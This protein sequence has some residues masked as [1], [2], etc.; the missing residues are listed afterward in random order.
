VARTTDPMPAATLAMLEKAT[1]AENQGDAAKEAVGSPPS[2]SLGSW[3]VATFSAAEKKT[4]PSVAL[5]AVSPL[6]KNAS[7][8]ATDEADALRECLE[9]L[10]R[11]QLQSLAKR[12]RV[13]AALSNHELV[14]SLL[15][16]MTAV[17]QRPQEDDGLKPSRETLR[18]DRQVV[19]T[20]TDTIITAQE[21]CNIKRGKRVDSHR[22]N[23]LPVPSAVGPEAEPAANPSA[24]SQCNA[25]CDVCKLPFYTASGK[26]VCVDCRADNSLLQQSDSDTKVCTNCGRGDS[27]ELLMLCDSCENAC[28]T[29]CCE[30]RLD[31]I[32]ESD[33]F[34][35]TCTHENKPSIQHTGSMVSPARK[36]G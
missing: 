34:C 14:G 17:R 3:D 33:W 6:M 28:H 7:G 12:L 5:F 11:K 36:Q 35:G 13:S 16:M 8:D 19:P 27:E 2:T 21:P 26:M 30:P 24:D 9:S 22:D 18:S 20:D 1:P 15:E 10:K 23:E 29:F 25:W 32:P 31:A 4:W